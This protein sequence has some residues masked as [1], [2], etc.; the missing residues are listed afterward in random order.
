MGYDPVNLYKV[1]NSWGSTWGM[2]GY[3][4]LSQE[5]GVCDYAMYPVTGAETEPMGACCT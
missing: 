5:T 2:S 3:A 1:K 4:Y